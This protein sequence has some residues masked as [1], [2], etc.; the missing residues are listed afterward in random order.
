MV[1]AATEPEI[2]LFQA[3]LVPAFGEQWFGFLSWDNFNP[4]AST[5]AVSRKWSRASTRSTERSFEIRTA[6]F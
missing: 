2:I 4:S 3:F 6:H 5:L 1:A